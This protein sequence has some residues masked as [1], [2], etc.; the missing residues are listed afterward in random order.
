MRMTSLFSS[1]LD[2]WLDDDGISHI[3]GRFYQPMTHRIE[4]YHCS[5]GSLRYKRSST[6]RPF[7]ERIRAYAK[8]GV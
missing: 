6:P 3:R 7:A 8:G 5:I 4:R 2:D 1:E